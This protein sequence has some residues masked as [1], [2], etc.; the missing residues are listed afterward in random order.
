M[1]EPLLFVNGVDGS[2]GSYLL[3]PL[4]PSD[5]S[6]AARGEPQ[7]PQ[8][9]KEL[10]WR[11]HRAQEATLG[12][13]EGID[14]KDLAATGWG[15]IF[16]QDADPAIREAMNNLLELR[17]KQ[18]GA[19]KSQYYREFSG[20]DGYRPGETKQAFLA[21]H[22]AGPGPA[23]PDRVPYY[24]LIVG[25]PET[26]PFGFQYQLDVQ[27]AVGRIHF[28]AIGEYHSYAQSVVAVETGQV[29]LP[30]Q[31]VFFGVCNPDDRATSLSSSELVEPLA[32]LVAA[33]QPDWTTQSWLAEDATKKRLA[34]VMG[35]ET[36]PALLFTAGHG[37]GFP[38]G[39][40]RQ[41]Q[42]QGALLCQ[43]WPGPASWRG[44]V[45]SDFY[46]SADDIGADARV[47]GL[48]S[49]HFAC[50]GAGTPRFDDFRRLM[51]GGSRE[52]A[53]HAFIA[54]LPRQLL[55]HPKGGALA[56]VSHV[57]RAW[58]Y[59]F[60]WPAAGPQLQVFESTLKR[61][62]SG[63]PIGSAMEYF[64]QR[65]A[66]LSSDLHAVLEDLKF[67]KAPD[68]VILSSMWTASND[69]RNFTIVGDPAVR[70]AVQPIGESVRAGSGVT[71]S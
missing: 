59:S 12:P 71:L 44:E 22:G 34:A 20:V 47:S 18:A 3:P 53:P 26:I 25:D 50:Y 30:R 29:H 19:R 10:K 1:T 65:Y 27:Y 43:D 49:F 41:L 15:V 61:L 9:L 45:P 64:N 67:G 13:M 37:I 2:T 16:A 52:I 33:S 56:V 14:P 11:L 51:L 69:A 57:E 60:A 63:H 31:A 21:R 35:A 7:D 40:P 54:R 42:C 4:K 68:E 48:V 70:L 58:S 55:S 62:M 28:D 32:K 5:V 23:D 24:L 39:D 6:A 17:K 36:P 46:L 38:V 8:R 66:E